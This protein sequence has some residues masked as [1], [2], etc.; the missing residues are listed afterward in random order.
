M[1]SNGS[2]DN[3]AKY[4]VKAGSLG[5]QPFAINSSVYTPCISQKVNNILG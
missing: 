2:I 5:D 1:R 4:D 3:K